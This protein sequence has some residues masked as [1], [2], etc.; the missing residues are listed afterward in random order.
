MKHL[1]YD[2]RLQ[3][4]KALTLQSSFAAIAQTLGKNRTTIARE[5][6]T[7]ASFT[8]KPARSKCKFTCI[9][10]DRTKCPAHGCTKRV[11]SVACSKCA[12]YCDKF[13]PIVCE[14]L[15]RA[16]YVCN[17]CA[18][19]SACNFMKK[20]YQADAAQKQYKS[21]L[22]EARSGISLTDEQMSFLEET[23]VP[24][25]KKGLSIPAC[26]EAYADSMPVSIRTLY[27][28]IDRGLL[29]VDNT[30]LRRKLRRKQTKKKS[31]PVLHV[32]KHCHIG[33]TYADFQAFLQQ[34][35]MQN[36]C[37]MDSVEGRKGGKVLLTIFFR[38]C[39]LQLMYLREANTAASVTAVFAN[40]RKTLGEDF[41]RLLPLLLSDRGTEFTNPQ[42][43]EINT[44]TG[45][46][47][48]N[49]FYCDPQQTNQKSRCERNHEYIRYI[50][51]KGSSFD[52]LSQEDVHLMMNH[53]NSMPR[54]S[55]NAKAP[56]QLF[57]ELY[58]KEAAAKL[59][60]KYIPLDQLCLKPDLLIK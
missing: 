51:P 24:L 45:E 59:G 27:D 60:L 4:Q 38:D 19:R 11:C 10:E 28:Y 52:E 37:E 39:G 29:S 58:G 14:K 56:I 6:K 25:L 50:L 41:K 32:D 34:H 26:Y 57:V 48:T 20:M 43:I 5:V 13:E 54:G 40:L 33:R 35:P 7:Y 1:T 31:G 30:D 21:T 36:V 9:F 8:G 16:P 12:P 3:I 15:S 22:S 46:I 18:D 44:V 42:A 17:G 53:I 47:E 2:E 55:L 49:L 23:I